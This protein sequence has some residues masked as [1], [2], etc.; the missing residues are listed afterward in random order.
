[1]FAVAALLAVV[2][3]V[4]AG[5]VVEAVVAAA[6]AGAVVTEVVGSAVGIVFVV[7]VTAVVPAPGLE[8]LGLAELSE[9]KKNKTV[10]VNIFH[11]LELKE[12]MACGPL[13]TSKLS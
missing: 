6:V 4:S 12:R 11:F 2:A 1:M 9:S 8:A 10:V 13:N 7:A 5:V 3:V